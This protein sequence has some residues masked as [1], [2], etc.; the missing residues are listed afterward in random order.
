VNPYQLI[1]RKRDG[2]ELDPDELRAFFNGYLQGDVAEYQMSAF[3]MAVFFREL[4]V[5]ELRTLVDIILL[6]GIVVNLDGIPGR[7]VDKHSTG[8]VGDKVSLILAPLVASLGV[9]VPM[10][11]GRGLG[12]SGGTVDKLESIPGFRTHLTTAEYYAQLERVGCALI[13]QTDEVAPLDRRLYALRD[14]TGTVESI[15]LIASSIM[16]KKLAEGIDALLLDV[17]VGN[18]AFMTDHARAR[19]LARTMV[20]IGNAYGKDVIA[21][22][23]AMDRPLGYAI[24]NAL[25]VEESI[26]ALHGR[27]PAD[28]REITVAQAA[29]ML[30]LGGVANDVAAGA[31]MAAAALDD[32]RAA[33]KFRDIIEAQ[34]GNPEVVDDPALLPQAPF[35]TVLTAEAAGYIEEMDV[36]AIGNAAV[37]L[38]AGRRKLASRIDPAVGF[39][40]THKTGAQ[41]QAGEPWATVYA[42]DESTGM[43]AAAELRDAVRFGATRGIPLP[44]IVERLGPSTATS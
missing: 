27:G 35:R 7:K 11:S 6:S 4:S 19:T 2:D 8:G 9:P 25:E 34:G 18:G 23:T 28:L 32:G 3:L 10:M 14:V 24:G 38:G 12:H 39:H 13:T 22:I 33:Q 43:R 5:T 17:K 36:R 44:L 29:E 41:V 37:T 31:R 21:L 1:A 26:E 20:D 16:S 40:I 42:A 15:P 30:V